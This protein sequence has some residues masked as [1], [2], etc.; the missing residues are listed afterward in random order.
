MSACAWP[1]PRTC[2]RRFERT[3]KCRNDRP[4]APVSGRRAAAWAET[5]RPPGKFTNRS[6]KKHNLETI[7]APRRGM[8][9]MHL[10]EGGGTPPGAAPS[11][12]HPR[13][14]YPS[15][16]PAGRT[17]L[18]TEGQKILCRGCGVFSGLRPWLSPFFLTFFPVFFPAGRKFSCIRALFV[19]GGAHYNKAVV[20]CRPPAAWGR[21]YL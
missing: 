1:I 20:N 12:G 18:M 13:G 4:A 15:P 19:C 3:G 9:N 11:R 7:S 6:K 17:T 21:C 10:R 2:G 5:A 8:L 14:P 16:Q